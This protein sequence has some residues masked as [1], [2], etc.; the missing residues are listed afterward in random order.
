LT[1]TLVEC[2]RAL[3]AGAPVGNA[4]SLAVAWCAA[5]AL[6]GYLWARAAFRRGSR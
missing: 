4:A 6:A 5:I 3:L 1:L 2:L